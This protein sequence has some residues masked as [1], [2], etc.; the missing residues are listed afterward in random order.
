MNS[1]RQTTTALPLH[2]RQQRQQNTNQDNGPDNPL[3][4]TAPGNPY[5]PSPITVI[6]DVLV[7]AG[8]FFSAVGISHYEPFVRPFN[9]SDPDLSYPYQQDY[10]SNTSVILTVLLV[11]PAAV[12]IVYGLWALWRLASRQMRLRKKGS[13]TTS[14]THDEHYNQGAP[15]VAAYQDAVSLQIDPDHHNLAAPGTATTIESHASDTPLR[16]RTYDIDSATSAYPYPPTFRV[17]F[18]T[19][20]LTLLRTL[21]YALATAKLFTDAIKFWAGRYRPDFLSRCAWDATLKVCT[22]DPKIVIEGRRSFPSGHTSSMFAGM[23]VLALWMAGMGGVWRRWRDHANGRAKGCTFPS[24]HHSQYSGV[25]SY[26]P[27]EFPA[28][29]SR[30]N[31]IEEQEAWYTSLQRDGSGWIVSLSLLPLLPAF[32]VGI[33]RSQQY[34]HNPSDII[35]SAILGTLLAYIFYRV[36]YDRSGRPRVVSGVVSGAWRRYN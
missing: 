32:Y 1:N 7:L 12:C 20:L 2:Q 35:A 15:P 25:G 29:A 23:V 31:V 8:T 19:D 28:D 17:L 4:H 34:I 16:S 21:L 36:Y 6:I 11:P 33:S 24:Q 26:H 10:V 13:T 22:G 14:S 18:L 27:A 30:Y 9:P 5:L 3:S